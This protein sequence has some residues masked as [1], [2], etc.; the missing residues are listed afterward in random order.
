M[1]VLKHSSSFVRRT[2]LDYF[3]NNHNH[4]FV[5][6]SPVMPFYDPTLSFVNAGMNQFKNVLLG[7]E[8]SSHARVVNSQKCIRV[9]GK[10]N[11]L[12][13]VGHDTYH[14]TFFEMLGNWSFG[15]YFKKD[16]C[17]MA[18][19]FLT[20]PPISI[21][22]H[23]LFVT[24]FNGDIESSLPPDLETKDIWLSVGVAEDHI[25]PFGLKDNFWEMGKTGPCGPCTE[26]HFDYQNNSPIS[27]QNRSALVNKGCDEVIELW[28]IVFIQ[29]NRDENGL[30]KPLPIHH[31]DTGM[32]LERF[33]AVV[34]GKASNYDTD[35][36]QDLFDTITKFTGAPPYSGKFGSCDK[37]GLDAAYRILADH[38][39]MCTV[40]LADNMFPDQNHK[41][42]RVLRKALTI[43]GNDFKAQNEYKL[44]QEVVN[45]V[46]DILSPVYPEISKNI[47]KIHLMVEHESELIKEIKRST[48]KQWHSIVNKDNRLSSVFTGVEAAGLPF[49]YNDVICNIIHSDNCKTLSG[50]AALKLYD[51]YG[52][53]VDLI[54]DLSTAVGLN[55]YKED[56]DKKL[57]ELKK[58]RM[59]K[60]S[61]NKH[62]FL[63]KCIDELIYHSVPVTDDQFK[64]VYDKEKSSNSNYVFPDVKAEILSVILFHDNGSSNYN[65]I[66]VLVKQNNVNLKVGDEVGIVLNKTNFYTEAG[67][68][69][70]DTGSI[71]LIDSST[72]DIL[73]LLD[74][75]QVLK[76]HNRVLHICK[77]MKINDNIMNSCS[78]KTVHFVISGGKVSA[79][80][81]LN[82]NK[83]LCHMRN[84]TATHLINC[85]LH[86]MFMLTAQKSS[87][88]NDDHL[89]FSFTVYKGKFDKLDVMK[90]E[91]SIKNLIE[92]KLPVVR[93]T[94]NSSELLCLDDVLLI[95]GE[96]YPDKNILLI[97]ICDVDNRLISKEPCCGT[98]VY[99]TGDI[100]DFCLIDIKSKGTNNK[101]IKAVTGDNARI[102]LRNSELIKEKIK[103]YGEKVNRLKN[104]KLESDNISKF[105]LE[106]Q[107]F[108]SELL[109][110]TDQYFSY[111]VLLDA[112][113]FI[114]NYLKELKKLIRVNLKQQLETEMKD[115]I[116]NL[117]DKK[118]LIHFVKSNCDLDTSLLH[119]ATKMCPSDV[120]VMLFAYSDAENVLK[121]RCSVP[122]NLT[123]NLAADKWIESVGKAIGTGEL[124]IRCQDPK[125]VC[126]LKPRRVSKKKLNDIINVVVKEAEDVARAVLQ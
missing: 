55:F 78:S 71:S 21:S 108:K 102:A 45:R 53:D 59:Q 36:F 13:V 100:S 27:V 123:N 52:L 15:D 4:V 39:R 35:L 124:N 46:S 70:S 72:D 6:S 76:S 126:G 79:L 42:R 80:L 17:Q 107:T 105:E 29:Y 12:S 125:L 24:Y 10:H 37:N 83:R 48:A 112:N 89:L 22:P 51:T 74:V 65:N 25:L 121:G 7:H 111:S 31:V 87:F 118:Y 32:G 19:N 109:K 50:D 49:A 103:F 28:N 67:G 90:L 86:K 38:S 77:V 104:E 62:S 64:Y 110:S 63:D 114:D 122:L 57:F 47:K 69:S 40:A 99:N 41:L 119:K 3:I 43:A 61:S 117:K 68:Q 56:F 113:E 98:H 97:E 120:A 84:H 101:S 54:E 81:Q 88:I 92:S 23:Q 106:L 20:S 58:E 14:H 11:D 30:L 18:W 1:K 94:V 82:K 16:A 73:C 8:Q 95:P 26:I 9:G 93:K 33:V 75:Q 5:R 115:V 2:F 116:K 66:N 34:Q 60:I 96:V 91:N 85:I 44:I